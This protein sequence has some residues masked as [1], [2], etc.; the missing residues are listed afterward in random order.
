M[1]ARG[2]LVGEMGVVNYMMFTEVYGKRM[3]DGYVRSSWYSRD[4]T[5][6]E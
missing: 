4:G 2:E 6:W 3:R 1:G 5:G